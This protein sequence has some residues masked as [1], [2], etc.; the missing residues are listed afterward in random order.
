MRTR[1]RFDHVLRV[2]RFLILTGQRDVVAAWVAH[3]IRDMREPPTKD[4]EAIG[5]LD[6]DGNLIGGFVYT[7]Y[8][9]LGDGTFNICLTAAGH[10][11]W[12]TRSNLRAFMSYPFRQLNCS[13][14]SAVIAKGN[15]K[16]RNIAERLGFVL[17]GKL[18]WWNGAGHDAVIYSLLRSE[19]RWIGE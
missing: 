16:S 6:A 18:R 5:A 2:R 14:M 7:E 3:Q 11:Y 8:R 13:R 19:C 12:L 1:S 10:G 17:E 9:R 15:R 4:F